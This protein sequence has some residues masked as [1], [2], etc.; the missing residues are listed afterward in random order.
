M[1][2][3]NNTNAIFSWRSYDDSPISLTSIGSARLQ[4]PRAGSI[5]IFIGSIIAGIWHDKYDVVG[6]DAIFSVGLCCP[7]AA[8]D[9]AA[10]IPVIITDQPL[11]AIFV[12]VAAL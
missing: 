6:I 7:V 3:T 11:G 2:A 8:R 4:E 5:H 12:R 10:P 1:G 9:P